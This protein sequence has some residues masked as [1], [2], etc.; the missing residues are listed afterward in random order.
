MS[1][2]LRP[3]VERDGG[4]RVGIVQRTGEHHA[5][6]GTRLVGGRGEVAAEDVVAGVATVVVDIGPGLAEEVA[7]VAGLGG[8]PLDRQRGQRRCRRARSRERLDRGRWVRR[9][10]GRRRGWRSSH[11]RGRCPRWCRGCPGALNATAAEQYRSCADGEC[12]ACA[13][14]RCMC[15][16]ATSCPPDAR[17]GAGLRHT[18]AR[19][20]C[21]AATPPQVR[22]REEFPG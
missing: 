14:A 10:F 16:S 4:S 22:R 17:A 11:G 6:S 3:A 13:A 19:Q 8:A 1:A 9:W 20:T 15:H 5:V 2:D 21:Q 12:G 18:G 7:A